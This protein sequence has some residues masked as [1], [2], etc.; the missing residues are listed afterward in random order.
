[1]RRGNGT[2]GGARLVFFT[3]DTN[4]AYLSE[5]ERK[6]SE[7]SAPWLGNVWHGDPVLASVIKAHGYER[8]DNFALYA[9]ER[10]FP[11]DFEIRRCLGQ[12]R[13]EAP[14]V[15]KA[16]GVFEQAE[17]EFSRDEGGRSRDEE[18]EWAQWRDGVQEQAT[19][20]WV[21]A[22]AS[23]LRLGSATD[24]GYPEHK[25]R[26]SLLRDARLDEDDSRDDEAAH[27]HDQ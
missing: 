22:A 21:M 13:C 3:D 11:L 20:R 14:R 17:D 19:A 25:T 18:Q 23:G 9:V 4:A 12:A 26:F 7:M 27:Y 10:Q 15:T 16:R 6:L 1:M 24:C 5:L 2:L 8:D